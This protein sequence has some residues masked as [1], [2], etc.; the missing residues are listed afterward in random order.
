[1]HYLNPKLTCCDG[2][3]NIISNLIKKRDL[4]YYYIDHYYTKST[5]EF[6]EKIMK[7]D[8]NS[9]DE[10]RFGIIATYFEINKITLEKINYIENKTLLKLNDIR[11]KMEKNIYLN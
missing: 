7:G 2:F 6:I 3:G 8:V 9:G 10:R 5:E 4:K 1:M 11:K